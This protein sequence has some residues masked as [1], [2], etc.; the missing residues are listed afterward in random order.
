MDAISNET[1]KKSN[2]EQVSSNAER[3]ARFKANKAF[4]SLPPD[5]QQSIDRLSDSPEEKAN[6]TAIALNYQKM[7]PIN[8][9]RGTGL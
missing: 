3:Q 8:V 1:A 9:H 6:R 4:K 5:V 7:F 2:A